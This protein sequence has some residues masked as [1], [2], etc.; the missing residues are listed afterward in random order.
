MNK[1]QFK[2]QAIV[3]F[4]AG[5]TMIL[6]SLSQGC[7][8]PPPPMDVTFW[9]GDP[10]KGGISRSQEN[11]TIGCHEPEFNDYACLTYADMQKI[12]AT[13]LKCKQWSVETMTPRQSMIVMRKNA[14]VLQHVIIREKS[15]QQ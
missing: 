14:E 13:I 8:T 9:A 7:V 6:I 15:G 10:D 11:K 2:E 1:I 12:Y 4:L 5:V 3:C